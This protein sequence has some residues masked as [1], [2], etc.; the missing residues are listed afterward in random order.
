LTSILS[1]K[2]IVPQLKIMQTRVKL[3]GSIGDWQKID[4]K[5]DKSIIKQMDETCV[6]AVG[7][8]LARFYGLN[9]SQLEILENIGILSNS[10][11]LAT[12]L[13]TKETDIDVKWRGGGWRIETP[14]QDLE[15]LLSN[16]KIGAMLR[17]KSTKGHAVFIDGLNKNGMVIVKDPFDQTTYTMK[18]DSFADIFS[19]FV[20]RAK[21]R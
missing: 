14:R 1:E 19:E 11:A 9:L 21:K 16:N 12:F 7:E 18:L 3:F 2:N 13:N 17:N 8:M 15:W 20:W 10:K 6:S 4:E 5:S